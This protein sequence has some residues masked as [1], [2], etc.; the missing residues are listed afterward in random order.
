MLTLEIIVRNWLFKIL[1]NKLLDKEKIRNEVEFVCVS[2][3]AFIYL[4]REYSFLSG[5]VCV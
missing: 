5:F 1:P 2:F 4:F 3:T